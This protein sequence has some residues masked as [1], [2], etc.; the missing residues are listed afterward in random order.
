M[1][2]YILAKAESSSES[3]CTCIS[4][5]KVWLESLPWQTCPTLFCTVCPIFQSQSGRC[6]KRTGGWQRVLL[7]AC[8]ERYII[9]YVDGINS[10]LYPSQTPQ[11]SCLLYV[12]AI[13]VIPYM[14]WQHYHQ[15]I[16][17]CCFVGWDTWCKHS[18]MSIRH[19]QCSIVTNSGSIPCR[20]HTGS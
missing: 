20:N 16:N 7:R 12:P 14:L 11:L 3:C 17:E 10:H 5:V 19:E 2:I 8:R 4:L 15:V 13:K 9:T 1:S 18:E 6:G